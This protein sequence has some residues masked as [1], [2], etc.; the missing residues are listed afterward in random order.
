MRLSK[1][2]RKYSR[3]LLLVFMSLLLVVFL[4][5]DVISRATQGRAMADAE[6]GEAFGKKITTADLRRVST[7]LGIV[8]QLGVSPPQ[9]YTQNRE[10]VTLAQYLLFEEARQ[11]GVRVS[12]DL[13]EQMLQ[14]GGVTPQQL[15]DVR[16]RSRLS[17]ESL[18]D[19]VGQWLAVYEVVQLQ[20][21]ALGDSVPRIELAFRDRNQEATVQLS[22]IETRAF[23]PRVSE[24]TEEEL[25][26]YFDEAKDRETAHT[27]DGLKFGYRLPDRVR[28]E[29]LTV[30]PDEIV[31][32][33][34]VRAKEAQR[35]YEEN[36]QNYVKR[37][38]RPPPPTTQPTRPEFD[39][40]QQTYE[41]VEAQVRE[42]CRKAK[43]ISEAQR[44]VNEMQEEADR[45]WVPAG[46]DGFRTPTSENAVV[47]F[48]ALRDKYQSRYPV[49]YRK[50]ELLDEAG[51]R[52]LPGI[53]RAGYRLGNARQRIEVPMLALRVKGLVKP[54]PRDPIPVLNVLEPSRVV[55]DLSID[56]RAR[57]E[58]PRQAYFFRVV[59]VAPAGPPASIDVV[60]EQLVKDLKLIRAHELAGE[61]ARRLAER[62]SEVG[63]AAA[64][65]SADELRQILA[66]AE[67]WAA[68]QPASA[69]ERGPTAYT[70]Y[71]GP[72]TPT[73]RFTRTQS[74]V[75]QYVGV[76]E[77][78]HKQVFALADSPNDDGQAHR[79]VAVPAA[80]KHKWIVAELEE[81]KPIYAGDFV[82]QQSSIGYRDRRVTAGGFTIAWFERE[83]ILKRTGFVPTKPPEAETDTKAETDAD[84]E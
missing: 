55:F 74:H 56:R 62:A 54:E 63:L 9:V 41:E 67:Q 64:V 71:L 78:L 70:R 61:Y 37:V 26:A 72:I 33:I 28:I 44:L 42:D 14:R 17:L 66:D 11:L 22:V 79:V 40:I 82:K 57:R 52:R 2:F 36:K 76:V 5:G 45:P 27:E 1:I 51:L 32:S 48:E 15:A 29:Y 38:P 58:T 19:L 7:E 59:E 50:S 75:H 13:V 47:S 49:I 31:N 12:R 8:A 81:V 73:G 4:I 83:N 60:R 65:E 80:D 35:Y 3:V 21:D 20:A 68:S 84:A 53:G 46:D 39:E 23:L 34:R 69:A 30:D 24:P 16:D 25:Q 43:A 77:G 6:I 18:Y 10:D